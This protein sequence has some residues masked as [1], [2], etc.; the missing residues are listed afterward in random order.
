VKVF[1]S[2]LLASLCC[3]AFAQ[4]ICIDPGHPSENGV[5]THGRHISEVHAAWEVGLKLASI[6]SQDGYQVVMTKSEEN[7]RVT[8]KARAARGN[9]AGASL[10]IRLH[11]DAGSKP[12]FASYYPAQTGHVGKVSGPSQ[13]VM[14]ESHALAERFHPAVIAALKG[15]MQD[16]GLHTEAATMIGNRQGA[17]TGSI[18]SKVPVILVEM[19]VLQNEH[20][21]LYISTEK[22][23]QAI[24]AAI[25]KGIE[26]AVP[27]G[28]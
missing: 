23:Q 13:E 24:A 1:F 20:D 5:G 27:R 11:C 21:D 16:R 28:R 10:M 25:A 4:T 22:G 14:Q 7:E 6:L 17:L 2:A 9:E 15:K 18:Y 12:G 26:T 19:A 3:A 8:N